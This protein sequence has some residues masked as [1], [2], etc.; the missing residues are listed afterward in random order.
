MEISAPF[1][2]HPGYQLSYHTEQVLTTLVPRIHFA[3]PA[4]PDEHGHVKQIYWKMNG[5]QVPVVRP[6]AG[7]HVTQQVP[8]DLRRVRE[9]DF[10]EIQPR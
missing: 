3:L 8:L 4:S 2:I 6:P 10:I 9:E 5:L 7:D 1:L